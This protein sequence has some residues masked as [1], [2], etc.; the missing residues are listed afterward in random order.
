[1]RRFIHT[2]RP[3]AK[4]DFKKLGKYEVLERVGTHTYKL[5]LPSTMKIHLVF[6]VSLLEPASNNP[7][8]GQQQPPP[9]PTIVENEEEYEVEEIFDSRL[10]NNKLQY[11]VKWSGYHEPTWEPATF[12]QTA[13]LITKA[14]HQKYPRKQKPTSSK[15]V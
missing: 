1:M 13:P 3:S 11:V 12:L 7:L 4:L 8:K 14:F 2:T 9:P 5:K 10:R 6:H 15:N